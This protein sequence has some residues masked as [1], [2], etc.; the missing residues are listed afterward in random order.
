MTFLIS[1]SKAK[2]HII[3]NMNKNLLVIVLT[4]FIMNLSN[5]QDIDL[6]IIVFANVV[7]SKIFFK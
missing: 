7:S 1:G 4:F 6:G 5:A 2:N 3:K